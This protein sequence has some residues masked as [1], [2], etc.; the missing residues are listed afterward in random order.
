MSEHTEEE[1]KSNN[2]VIKT[3]EPDNTFVENGKNKLLNGNEVDV[4]ILPKVGGNSIV[5]NI[6]S[7]FPISYSDS[8]RKN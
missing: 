8:S 5:I 7:C 1:E 4:D 6:C 2:E 3:E